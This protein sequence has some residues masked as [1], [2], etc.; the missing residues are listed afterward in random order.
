[1]VSS[2]F[3]QDAEPAVKPVVEAAHNANI[4]DVSVSEVAHAVN[5]ERKAAH[6]TTKEARKT[7]RKAAKET[8]KESRE[9]AKEAVKKSREAAKEAREA[10]KEAARGK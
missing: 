2:A 10:A 8:A 7:A 1:M 6:E 9:A 3:A 5:E 4:S